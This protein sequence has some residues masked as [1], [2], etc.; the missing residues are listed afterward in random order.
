[1]SDTDKHPRG[2]DIDK[3]TIWLLSGLSGFPRYANS[4]IPDKCPVCPVCPLQKGHTG[5]SPTPP[6]RQRS[7]Q[8]LAEVFARVAERPP[9]A[10]GEEIC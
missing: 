4:D 5:M 1:M 3:A 8:M 2:P 9:A 10:R 7:R 6:L